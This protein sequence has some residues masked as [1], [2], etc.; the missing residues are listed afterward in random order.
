MTVNEKR[1]YIATI[2]HSR[3]DCYGC[4]L[5]V[6]TVRQCWSA[7]TDEEIEQNYRLMFLGEREDEVND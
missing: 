6:P 2:C 4:P 3:E 7:A 1:H 5:H